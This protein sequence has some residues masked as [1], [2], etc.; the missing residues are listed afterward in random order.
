MPRRLVTAPDL[1]RIAVFAALIAALG[2]P[3]QLSLG[4][5]GVPVT[6]QTLGVML[7]GAILG[8]WKGAAAVGVF[9]VVGLALPVFAGGRT[10]I[11]A[12]SSTTIGY[13][14]GFFFGA[15]AVGYLTRLILPGYRLW[16]AL[17]VTAVGGIG[18]I[19]LFGTLGLMIR[20]GMPLGAAVASNGLYLIGD[21]LKVVV[22][23]VVADQVHRSYPGLL[24]P[25]A[26]P[27]RLVPAEP[28]PSAP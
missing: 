6:L 2:L 19:Y 10:T 5:T 4:S 24:K 25:A 20:A 13:A 11:A 12:Y 15:F 28:A 3:G 8:P 1:A 21:V 9:Q 26:A 22:T 18:V 16:A 17:L 14:V 7:A 23:V 27:K